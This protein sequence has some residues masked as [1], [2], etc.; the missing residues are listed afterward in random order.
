M[1]GGIHINEPDLD[2]WSQ[3]LLDV[4]LDTVQVTAYARQAAWNGPDV[5]FANQDPSEVI[6]QLEAAKRAKL[7]VSLVLRT[8]LEHALA[9]NR[10]LWHGRIHPQDDALDGWFA[11]YREYALWGARLAAEYDVELLVIGNELNSMTSTQFPDEAIN[12]HEYF[13]D[14]DRTAK[15]RDD[16]V[17]CADAVIERGDG[18]DLTHWDGGRF[19]TLDA[20]LI[21]AERARRDWAIEVTGGG[22]LEEIRTTL[23]AR[24]RDLD[25]RWRALIV[26]VRD[27]YA[28]P[29]TYGANF[30]QFQ[31]VG[32]WDALDAVGVTSYFPLSLWGDPD[33]VPAMDAAWTD[34]AARLTAAGTIGED[35]LP[36]YLLELGWTRLDGST[37][38]PW[39]YD[40]VDVLETVGEVE[41]GAAQPL[42]CVHWASQAEDSEERVAALKSLADLVEAD[43][44][45]ALRGFSLWKLTTRDYHHAGERFAVLVP[46]DVQNNTPN[47]PDRAML[48]EAARLGRLLQAQSRK[49]RTSAR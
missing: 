27:V 38:R 39:S 20:Q 25:T 9:E 31:N 44:F 48:R 41:P 32:F 7:K 34:V 33:P 15:V 21:D 35:P 29:V 43:G 12:P 5:G 36:I 28:G 19:D 1:A 37:V 16:L 18:S 6:V 26:D 11:N 42:T 46:A 49:R 14:P 8:Y 3:A 10:H 45:E 24:G 23:E 17:A 47:A 40:R 13:L 2:A 22:S 4:G 30:D